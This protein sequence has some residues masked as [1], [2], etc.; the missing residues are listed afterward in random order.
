MRR[1][2]NACRKAV[3]TSGQTFEPALLA[4][5]HKLVGKPNIYIDALVTMPGNKELLFPARAPLYNEMGTDREID[6]PVFQYIF[7][8]PSEIY[9]FF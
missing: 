9:Y 8:D 6:A 7:D 1:V 2:V 4:V 5:I 3:Y